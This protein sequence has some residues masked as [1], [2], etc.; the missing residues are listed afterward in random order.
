MLG[1]K[2]KRPYRRYAYHRF[3]EKDQV[4]CTIY[5]YHYNPIME[6]SGFGMIGVILYNILSYILRFNHDFKIMFIIFI[7]FAFIRLLTIIEKDKKLD[8]IDE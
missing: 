3:S 2:F 4:T 6:I 7:I 1:L 8:G 5:R